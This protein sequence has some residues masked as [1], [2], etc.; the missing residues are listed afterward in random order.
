MNKQK[1]THDIEEISKRF[2]SQ[3]WHDSKIRSLCFYITEEEE[4]R[5]AISLKLLQVEGPPKLVELIFY[6]SMYFDS[7]IF[8]EGKKRCSDDL[9]DAE[10]FIESDWIARLKAKNPLKRHYLYADPD[11]YFRGYLH[12]HFDLCNPEDGS[13]DI[14]AK[15]FSFEPPG[16]R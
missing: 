1:K 8:F 2:N 11:E 10:C 16:S 14:L 3:Q 6:E 5:I 9:W 15:D 4:D 7:E 12:F 13:I